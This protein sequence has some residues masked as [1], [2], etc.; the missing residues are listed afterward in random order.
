MSYGGTA[1]QNVAKMARAWRKRLEKAPAEGLELR[2]TAG[3]PSSASAV[4]CP[5]FCGCLASGIGRGHARN[6]DTEGDDC[7]ARG[8]GLCLGLGAC[9]VRGSL[10][11]PPSAKAAG[12]AKSAEAPPGEPSPEAA[13][14][15]SSRLHEDASSSIRCCAKANV[16]GATK[17]AMH[18]FHYKDGVLHAEDVC[19]ARLAA[20][21]GTP[22]YCYSTA[23]LTRHYAC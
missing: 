8:C 20:E 7:R 13:A 18:H 11:P 2:D 16:R 23:T 10:D 12:T 5:G 19:L 22:F 6:V 4:E 1:P 3:R 14:L 17:P 15:A 9:G 21:V